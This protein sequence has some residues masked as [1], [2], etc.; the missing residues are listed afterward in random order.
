MLSM[1]TTNKLEISFSAMF[2]V[3]IRFYVDDSVILG[4]SNSL[5]SVASSV[6]DL[7]KYIVPY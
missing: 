3:L 5:L 7:F 6:S 2:S 1:N 4:L